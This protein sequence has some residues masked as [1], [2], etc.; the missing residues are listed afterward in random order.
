MAG[1][2][3]PSISPPGRI[4]RKIGRTLEVA[5]ALAFGLW[6]SW[7]AYRSNP[8]AEL[9]GA[10]PF[11]PLD[12]VYWQGPVFLCGIGLVA[13]LGMA[14]E[15]LR[16]RSPERWGI[17]RWTFAIACL[18]TLLF[19]TCD[20]LVDMPTRPTLFSLAMSGT[21]VWPDLAPF[22]ISLWITSRFAGRPQPAAP[23]VREW[24]GRIYAILILLQNAVES[25]YS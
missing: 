23:D 13:G 4:G 5:V 25:S 17:G 15:K 11:S 19:V 12:R 2:D 16:G 18:Y 24:Y 21:E 14:V 6:L 10:V 22:L 9:E 8:F 3:G 7:A 1:E 20:T